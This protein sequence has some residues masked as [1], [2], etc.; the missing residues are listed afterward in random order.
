MRTNIFLALGT[1]AGFIF[2]HDFVLAGAYIV[3]HSFTM[4]A[5]LTAVPCIILATLPALAVVTIES[6]TAKKEPVARSPSKDF[7]AGCY[8]IKSLQ[9]QMVTRRRDHNMRQGVVIALVLIATV[10]AN[11]ILWHTLYSN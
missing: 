9:N 11:I 8:N 1:V 4:Q 5:V 2:G 6:A 7:D 3:M 10:I